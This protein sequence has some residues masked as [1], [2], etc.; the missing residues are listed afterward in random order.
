MICESSR[1]EGDCDTHLTPHLQRV[2]IYFIN[3]IESHK[4]QWSNNG[5]R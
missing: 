3:L 2:K 5:G 1:S 4:N